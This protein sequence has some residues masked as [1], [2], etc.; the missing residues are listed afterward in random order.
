MAIVNCPNCGKKISDKAAECG[1]CRQDI[2]ALTPEK[3][4]QLE[5]NRRFD[6]AQRLMN[7]SM[8]ALVMFLGGFGIMYWWQPESGSYNRYLAIGA[9]AVGFVW[10]IITR[11]RI[12]LLKRKK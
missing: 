9:I 4:E 10:Y 6:Q 8:I 1:H 5:R 3:L 7:H 11:I 2:S 12:I